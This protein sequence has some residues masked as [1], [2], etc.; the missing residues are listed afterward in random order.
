MARIPKSYTTISGDTWD[1]IAYKV[2]GNEFACTNL[3]D[4][5]REYL[6]YMVFP[7]GIVLTLPTAEEAGQQNTFLGA[8]PEWRAILNG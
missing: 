2:Y 5:N 6:D 8:Y 1:L 3:M 4:K 7:A